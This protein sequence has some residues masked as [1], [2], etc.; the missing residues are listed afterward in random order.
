MARAIGLLAA[1]LAGLA[2][3]SAA[4]ADFS[5]AP[6]A[7]ATFRPWFVKFGPAGLILSESAE[8]AAGGALVPGGTVKVDPQLTVAGEI[9]YFFTPNLAA[10]FTGGFP[11][12]VRVMGKGSVS[13]S[14]AWAP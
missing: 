5:A 10:S 7:V 8:I 4:A 9:G 2:S 1:A 3:G 6:P 11:P 14:G 12:T 13:V